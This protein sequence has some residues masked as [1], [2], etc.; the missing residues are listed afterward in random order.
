MWVTGRR[1]RKI[2]R[3]LALQKRGEARTDGLMLQSAFTRLGVTWSAR[4]IHPWDR[5]DP[6]NRKAALFVKHSLADTETAIKRLFKEL[7]EID[8]IEVN[9]LENG[10]GNVIIA[11]TVRR[12]SLDKTANSV[13]MRLM[14]SGIRFSLVG[15]HFEP[16]PENNHGAAEAD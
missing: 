7:P 14:N 11:G 4:D 10:S 16:L 12:S 13:R 5:E 1:R 6:P 8:V 15:S 3:A 9:V 2:H